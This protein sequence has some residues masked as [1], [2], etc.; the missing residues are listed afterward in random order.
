MKTNKLALGFIMIMLLFV[1]A[2]NNTTQTTENHKA[3]ETRTYKS[4]RGD[5]DIPTH[6]KRIVTDFYTGELL[7]VGANVVGS[8]SWSFKNP[9]LKDQLKSVTDLGDPINVEKVMKLKPDL[10]VI[11]KEDNYDKLSKI[12][13]TVVIPYNTTKNIQ[14]TGKMFGDITGKKDKAK[15]F[16][17]DFDQKSKSARQKIA[18]VIDKDATFGIYENTDKGKFWVFN[19]NGGR[20]GQAIYNALGLKAPDQINKDII[21]T[22]EMKELSLEVIPEYAAD[23]M[24]ITDYNPN[25]DSKT[26]AKLKQSSIW[27]NLEAVKQNRVFIND[28]NT[29]YPYDPISV[30]KQVDL[31]TEMLVKRAKENKT[32]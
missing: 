22:G 26:L 6:P 24:F 13:P 19:D 7:T 11:M 20:G 23:Y 10:I 2:C 14:E 29:F 31:I 4:T 28:F 18:K 3:S 15:Q 17:A 8:G 1:T 30:S 25:G 5:V 32:K 16:L 27:N 9:F 21:K 12:A